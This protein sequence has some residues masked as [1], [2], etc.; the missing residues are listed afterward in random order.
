[1][2]DDQ[3]REVAKRMRGAAAVTVLTGAGISASSDVPTFRGPGGLWRNRRPEELATPGAFAADPAGVWEW[4]DWRR[5]KMA[6]CRPNRGHDVLAA[7]SQRIEGFTLI[8]QNVDGLHERAGTSNVIRFHGSIWELRCCD[9]CDE[10]REAWRDETVPFPELPV[11]CPSCGGLARPGVVWFGEAI[12]PAVIDRSLAATRCDLFLT[13]GTSAV[14]HPAAGLVG[15]AQ[16]RGAFTVELNLEE[17]PASPYVN[18][19]LQGSADELLD[20]IEAAQDQATGW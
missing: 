19:S 15:D 17:T 10:R 9:P 13:I 11:R 7:W 16:A 14:V 6:A 12:D 5:Q 3:I 2:P 20:A 8:T 18:L 1:M 4:Y